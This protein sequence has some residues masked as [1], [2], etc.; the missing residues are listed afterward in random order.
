M[1]TQF[2]PFQRSDSQNLRNL[3]IHMAAAAVFKN[4]KIAISP[5]MFD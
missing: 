1:V 4:R 3:K 2:N 5:Q